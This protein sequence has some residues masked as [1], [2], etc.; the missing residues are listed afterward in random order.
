MEPRTLV[1][2][3]HL[4]AIALFIGGQLMLVLAVA[5][6]MRREGNEGTMRAMAKRFGIGS[7]VALVV[8][9]ATGAAMASE[10]SRWDDPVLHAKLAVLLLVA[11][12][13]ALHIVTPHSRAV[14][15]AVVASSIFIL[16]LGTKLTHG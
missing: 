4:A 15:L 14:S 1:R 13:V 16:W 12:L 5:P 8:L 10:F 11:V 3:L 6:V 7:A 9:L 2:F